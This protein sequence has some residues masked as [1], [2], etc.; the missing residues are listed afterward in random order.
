MRRTLAI[1]AL[2]MLLLATVGTTAAIAKPGQNSGKSPVYKWDVNVDPTGTGT[3]TINAKAHTF[4]FN[5]NG[6]TSGATC[7]VYTSLS[8]APLGS[9]VVP[10]SGTVHITGTCTATPAQL[11]TATVTATTKPPSYTFD[12]T[13][14]GASV[15][16]LTIDTQ[17]LTFVFDG[18]GL[19]PNTGTIYSIYIDQ[20]KQGVNI[21]GTVAAD[22]TLHI[23]GSCD[24]WFGIVANNP[25]FE[26]TD[27]FSW[28]GFGDW[29]A[30]SAQWSYATGDVHGTLI[31]KG[32]GQPLQSAVIYVY[33]WDSSQQQYVKEG[34]VLT[35]ATGAYS[36]TNLAS[37]SDPVNHP[38]LVKCPGLWTD[39]PFDY[40]PVEAY[41]T[42]V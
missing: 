35:D 17:Q 24:Q 27:S 11:D 4:V 36:Y 13:Y 33:G 12:V 5:G 23:Q 2:V 41:A 9:A 3:L 32:N 14:E 18:Q 34:Y 31:N 26:L 21:F 10:A 29:A 40:S 30:L 1:L 22:G 28:V 8:A 25:T 6:L 15:G 20:L 38:P 39:T 16:K 37:I 19:T 42:E 7:Y